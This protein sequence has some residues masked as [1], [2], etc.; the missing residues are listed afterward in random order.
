MYTYICMYMYIYSLSGLHWWLSGKESACN[1][2]AAEDV[3]LS[4]GL[5]RSTPHP[6][7][8]HGNPLQ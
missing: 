5:G 8:G 7:G 1:A 3:G 4:P 6:E 2:G